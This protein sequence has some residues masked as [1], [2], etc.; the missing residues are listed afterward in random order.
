MLKLAQTPVVEIGCFMRYSL[1]MNSNA[2]ATKP[3]SVF[4]AEEVPEF[5]TEA[6]EQRFW[7]THTPTRDYLDSLPEAEDEVVP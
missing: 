6:D 3:I 7:S 4:S 5:A 1:R 2:P